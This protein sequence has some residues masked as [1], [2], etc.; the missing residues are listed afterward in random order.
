M[1]KGLVEAIKKQRDQK[2]LVPVSLDGSEPPLGFRQYQ[3]I[4]VRIRRGRLDDESLV[5]GIAQI[6]P[7]DVAAKQ[8]LLEAADVRER[9]DLLVQF[10]RFFGA[11]GTVQ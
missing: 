5:N 2:K 1:K 4:P 7:F 6:I 8:A 3:S 9:A 10:L 11:G